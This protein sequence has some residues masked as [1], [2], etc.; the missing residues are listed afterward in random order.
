MQFEDCHPSVLRS[1]S[2]LPD[3][4]K[5]IDALRAFRLRTVDTSA[6]LGRTRNGGAPNA[7]AVDVEAREPAPA[8]L[9]TRCSGRGVG[10]VGRRRRRWGGSRAR[11]H[12]ARLASGAAAT[13]AP[14]GGDPWVSAAYAQ[15]QPWTR[16]P[17]GP[18]VQNHSPRIPHGKVT[19]WQSGFIR[20]CQEA[21][22]G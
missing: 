16:D 12:F 5:E 15:G 8:R 1:G 22:I 19:K 9:R 13:G 3:R 7:A 21:I 14:V 20:P 6:Q 11:G 18:R 2:L 17:R 10:V 4:V